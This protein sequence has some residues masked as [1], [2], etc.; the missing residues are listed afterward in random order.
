[1]GD[2]GLAIHGIRRRVSHRNPGYRHRDPG[3]NPCRYS[4]PKLPAAQPAS[5]PPFK[6]TPAR[7]GAVAD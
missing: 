1:M 7:M 4:E 6:A 2:V 3:A 5:F